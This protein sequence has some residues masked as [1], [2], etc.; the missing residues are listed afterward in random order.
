MPKIVKGGRNLYGQAIG[1][2]M[3]ETKFP[4]IPGDMGNATTWDFPVAYRIVKGASPTRVVREGD[5]KL[6]KPF[7]EAAQDLEKMGVRAITTNCG[8]LAMFQKE[9]ADAVNVPVFTSSLIQV[10]LVYRMLKSDQKVGIIT[11]SSRSLT[12]KHLSAVGADGIPMVIM[13]TEDGEEFTK[14]MLEDKLIYDIEKA[15][16]DLITVAERL[17]TQHPEIGAIV[18]ECTNM[19]PFAKFIQ[20]KTGLP[21]FDIYTLTNMVYHTI[22]RKEFTGYM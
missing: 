3:L 11:V 17:V 2:I 14:V 6:L 9:M 20:D 22:V 21:V 19:P 18:L 7:I 12:E 4:R 16:S 8:F 15:K 13:G 10:P 5:P 1:I